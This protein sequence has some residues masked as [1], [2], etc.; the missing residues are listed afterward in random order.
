MS[1]KAQSTLGSDVRCRRLANVKMIGRLLLILSLAACNAYAQADSYAKMVNS[2]KAIKLPRK[3]T[4]GQAESIALE[5]APA[6]SRAS[7]NTQAAKQG[8]IE[9]RSQLFPQVEGDL[10]AVG[11]NRTNIRIGASGALNNPLILNRQANGVNISQ[12]IFDFGRT[13]DLTAA[14]RFH[15]LSEAQREGMIRA[16]LLLQVAV[17]YFSVLKAEALLKV[18]NETVAARQNVYDEV[19]ALAKSKLKSDL[20]R[21][22]AQVNL[23]QA[24]QLV[25]QTNNAVGVAYAELSEAMGL[26][27]VLRFELSDA[28][29]EKFPR[30]DLGSLVAS[31]LNSRPEIVALRDDVSGFERAADAERDAR[32]P[33]IDALGS[34]GRTTIG[35]SAV[36]GNYAAAG[37]N[38]AVPVFTGGLLSARQ[39]EAKLR[40]SAEKKALEEEE[41][42]VVKE[43][44]AAWFNASTALK[45]IDV[46]NQLAASSEQALELAK[47]EYQNGQTSIIEYSQAQLNALQAEISA[48]SAKYDYQAQ[49]VQL[50]YETGTILL[51]IPGQHARR[52]IPIGAGK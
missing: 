25:L 35:S 24:K 31:A 37:I 44:N 32:L 27:E 34:L 51:N 6:I 29:V 38:V 45:N 10:S 12:L 50:D 49:R 15:A 33:Q 42:H 20:D 7:F 41:D 39:A 28:P 8:I 16:Q 40:A 19:A 36:Q 26:K 52:F 22:Y 3:L 4:L 23:G 11:T 2:S 30:E 43:V 18:A 47:S 21:T 5:R 46:A 17:T 9:A 1:S 13:L 48:A 14:A